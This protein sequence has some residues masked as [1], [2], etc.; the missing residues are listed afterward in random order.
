MRKTKKQTVIKRKGEVEK[1]QRKSE[2]KKKAGQTGAIKT[3][4][5]V[6]YPALEVVHR[7]PI[8]RNDPRLQTKSDLKMEGQRK[9]Q[10][11][12]P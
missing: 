8:D 10:E 4:R 7:E 6:L 2:R 3:V 12:D 11:S 1:R 9:P 5:S